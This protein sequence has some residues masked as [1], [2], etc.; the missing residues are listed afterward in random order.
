[1]D[2]VFACRPAKDIDL[3]DVRDGLQLVANEP[4]LKGFEF[5]HVVFR[6]GAGQ[7]EKH[8]LPGWAVVRAQAW[9]HA[10]RQSDLLQPVDYFLPSIQGRDLIVVNDRYY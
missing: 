7:G 4:I 9:T 6:I 2:L 10:L 5:H 1:M 3:H 8:D